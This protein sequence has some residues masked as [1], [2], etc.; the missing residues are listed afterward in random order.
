MTVL[1]IKVDAY[2]RQL[3][4]QWYELLPG[5]SDFCNL[6]N[7]IRDEGDGYCTF[8]DIGR[9][10]HQC[11]QYDRVPMPVTLK[12]TCDEFDADQATMRVQGIDDQGQEIFD[13]N[14]QRG[15]ELTFNGP[16]STVQFTEVTG[17]IKP[18]TNS[19]AKLVSI[20]S[21]GLSMVVG[22]YEP[23]ELRPCYRRYYVPEAAGARG[24]KSVTVT[25]LCQ[26]RHVE[27][28]QPNDL[29]FTANIG[30]LQ[31]SVLG[32]HYEEHGDSTRAEFHFNKAIG[33]LNDELKRFRPP[34][35]LGSVRINAFGGFGG[36]DLKQSL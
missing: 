35:E 25:A 6:S 5:T 14:G 27:V 28:T 24:L 30:A 26:R 16:T 29:L 2:A 11:G 18:P 32:L 4:N 20:D 7:Y 19:F 10:H 33:L 13:S 21:D 17:V 15:I 22:L 34:S 23:G 1:G 12:A 9:W 3:A 31:N 36:Q 8:G